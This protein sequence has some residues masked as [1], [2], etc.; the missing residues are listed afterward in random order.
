MRRSL[1]PLLAH[2]LAILIYIA[3]ALFPVFWLF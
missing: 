1:L 3:F 2:R